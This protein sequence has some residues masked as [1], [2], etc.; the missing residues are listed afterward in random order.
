MSDTTVGGMTE[1][2]EVVEVNVENEM[3][4]LCLGSDSSVDE[5]RLVFE[6]IDDETP[7]TFCGRFVG[8][9]LIKLRNYEQASRFGFVME[10]WSKSDDESSEVKNFIRLSEP[11]NRVE[12]RYS[13]LKNA[14][15]ATANGGYG[16]RGLTLRWDSAIWGLLREIESVPYSN[17]FSFPSCEEL[18]KILLDLEFRPETSESGRAI[19]RATIAIQ[20]A[21]SLLYGYDRC[22]SMSR[23]LRQLVD[24]LIDVHDRVR[25]LSMMSSLNISGRDLDIIQRVLPERICEQIGIPFSFESCL[26]DDYYKCL[27]FNV[28]IVFDRLCSCNECGS[29]RKD[30]M[31]RLIAN[32]I[33]DVYKKRRKNEKR[34]E[35]F[36]NNYVQV[37]RYPNLGVL[38]L[39]SVRHMDP[40]QQSVVCKYLCKDL[41]YGVHY[42]SCS[43]IARVQGVPLPYS[44]VEKMNL[45]LSYGLY[46]VNNVY[47]MCFLIRCVRDVVRTEQNEYAELIV[48]LV[49][50]AAA[51]LRE[52]VESRV[53]GGAEYPVFV[54][55]D[56]RETGVSDEERDLSLANALE[57]LTFKDDESSIEIV[58]DDYSE[59]TSHHRKIGGFC[60]DA[61]KMMDLVEAFRVPKALRENRAREELVLHTFRIRK[62]YSERPL[63]GFYGDRLVPYYVFVGGSRRRDGAAI[64]LD[65]VTLSDAEIV[66]G[67]WRS[68]ELLIGI[69]S[70]Y[71]SF[72]SVEMIRNVCVRRET[73]MMELDRLY[74]PKGILDYLDDE[75][76]EAANV[77]ENEQIHDSISLHDYDSHSVYRS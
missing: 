17:P 51:T 39:P 59:T 45:D 75:D 63:P 55:S 66:R 41:M 8:E 19:C 2:S 33:G 4:E 74:V 10:A 24:E 58:N 69:R 77:C 28:E 52:D 54:S 70:R 32:G 30:R 13:H 44:A 27:E 65:G 12:L 60:R 21:L 20:Y 34:Y 1:V 53:R 46:L 31:N 72:H 6:L 71:D 26:R 36:E 48:G 57:G 43:L 42:G 67:H 38:R 7:D 11:F 16:I 14:R 73:L 64:R 40:I 61:A 68:D 47:F 23:Y 50:D 62:M 25:H 15:F 9:H 18:S 5:S 37:T 56:P 3:G 29:R 76:G 22:G 35:Y 49:R